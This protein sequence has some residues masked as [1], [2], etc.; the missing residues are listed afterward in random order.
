MGVQRQERWTRSGVRLRLAASGAERWNWLFV[1]GG[2]GLGSQSLESL[3]E[4]V[5]V[6]GS[7]WL[8]DLPGDGSNRD[9][10]NVS[11]P[12][13]HWPD[14][15]VEAAQALDDVVMVGHSTGGMFM[16]SVPELE[17]QLAGLALIGSAPH[18]GW[19]TAFAQY[20][21]DHPIPA[22]D[23]AAARYAERPDDRNLRAL[24]LAATPWNFGEQAVPRGRALLEGAAYNHDAVAW[25]DA[26][27]DDIYRARWAPRTV[28]TLIVG[29]AQ[30][31]VVTQHLWQEEP[32]FTRPNI[33][34]R[35]IEGAAHFPWIDNPQAVHAAFT[36]LT[37][38][39]NDPTGVE[40][41]HR[42][43]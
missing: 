18:A 22:V 28:P 43:Q 31:H 30:D 14:V 15:L 41:A 10:P 32:A 6:P 42:K 38:R 11:D 16:L 36:D 4:V 17:E 27:F 35:R 39:L 8:V 29:G 19:R 2:P 24:T 26:H 13:A 9:L 23:T 7:A 5:R 12:Y 3:V 33:L 25:A 20:T 21:Q 37:H 34:H 1:P 40:I